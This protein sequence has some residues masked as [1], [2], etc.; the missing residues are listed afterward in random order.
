MSIEILVPQTKGH[1]PT[2]RVS[3]N[4]I[5]MLNKAALSKLGLKKDDRITLGRDEDGFYLV[6]GTDAKDGLKARV[7]K[8]GCIIVQ[9]TWIARQVL[10]WYVSEHNLRHDPPYSIIFSLLN[11]PVSPG[12]YGMVRPEKISNK[13]YKR[14][15]Q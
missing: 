7:D 13:P 14:K 9:N 1:T 8:A 15:K 4:G 5:I 3:Q 11:T 10:E 6:T 12:I 2:V